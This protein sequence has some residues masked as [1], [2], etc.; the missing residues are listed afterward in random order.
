[1]HHGGSWRHQYVGV[2]AC[3]RQN[4]VWRRPPGV[5]VRVMHV[6]CM[7]MV[8]AAHRDVSARHLR[9]HHQN[10]QDDPQCVTD[11]VHEHNGDQSYGQIELALSLLAPSP[12]QNLRF[13][14]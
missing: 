7:A 8:V 9:S 13:I 1:M 4:G 14:Y 10:S 6:S 11:D 2:P 5:D 3:V 12:T